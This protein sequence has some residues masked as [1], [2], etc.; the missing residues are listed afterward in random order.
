M[1]YGLLQTM[2]PSV[3][4]G[5]LLACYGTLLACYGTLLACY[6]TLL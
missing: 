1:A 5:T 3:D 6:G 4:Y 2:A